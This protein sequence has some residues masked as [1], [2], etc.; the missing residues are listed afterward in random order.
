[1][2]HMLKATDK[3]RE[4]RSVLAMHLY[5]DTGRHRWLIGQQRH[6][7]VAILGDA[8]GEID[9]AQLAEPEVSMPAMPPES[10]FVAV[11]GK[12]RTHLRC[13]ASG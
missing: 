3:R 10:A 2:F 13:S 5:V 6:D 11:S 1:M 7:L 8:T 4:R 9:H 12:T